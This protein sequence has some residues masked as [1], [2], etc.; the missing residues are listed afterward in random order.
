MRVCCIPKI[1]IPQASAFCVIPIRFCVVSIRYGVVNAEGPAR[2]IARPPIRSGHQHRQGI[3]TATVAAWPS[4]ARGNELSYTIKMYT[5]R[6]AERHLPAGHMR[7]LSV[8]PETGRRCSMAPRR[9]VG[10]A[11]K[12]GVHS[13][14]IERRSSCPRHQGGAASLRMGRRGPRAGRIVA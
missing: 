13:A 9:D 2:R 7:F 6:I 12:Y 10:W 5:V 1:G 3:I 4:I 14:A 11:R 8:T